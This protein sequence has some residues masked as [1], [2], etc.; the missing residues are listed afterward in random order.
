MKLPRFLTAVALVGALPATAGDP[1][2]QEKLTSQAGADF[3]LFGESVS[4]S[5]TTAV[6]GASGA[7][8]VAFNAGA[9]FVFVERGSE[10]ERQATLTAGDAS[11]GDFFGTSVAISAD[12]IVV[13]AYGDGA[14]VGAAYAFARVDGSW[15]Q[16]AKLRPADLAEADEFGRTVAVSG[17]V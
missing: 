14:E 6:V 12:T 16:R 7:D 8:V 13:G 1:S 17:D 3:D 11:A 9:A 10:Y 15:V 4:I 5:G 2:C